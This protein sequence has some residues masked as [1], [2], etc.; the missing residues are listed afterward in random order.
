MPSLFPAC[1]R[2]FLPVFRAPVGVLLALL[3]GCT[4]QVA[5]AQSAERFRAALTQFTIAL[6]GA[7]GDEG[8][9]GT[10]ALDAMTR[11]LPEWD[12]EI[13]TLETRAKAPNAD[14][15]AHAD[16]ARAYL[17]RGRTK[18]AGRE[19]DTARVDPTRVDLATLLGL[20][21]WTQQQPRDATSTFRAAWQHDRSDPVAAYWLLQ[22]EPNLAA[23][24]EG[25][26]LIETLTAAY[27][28]ALTLKT[29][30]SSAP[31][32]AAVPPPPDIGDAPLLLPA[33]YAPGYA[34]LRSGNASGAIAQFRAA[35]QSDPLVSDPAL[36]SAAMTAGSAALRQGRVSAARDQFRTAVQQ[37]PASSEAHRLL[38]LACLFDF[39]P[40]TSIS[41]LKAAVRL[42]PN[43]ERSRILLARLLTQQGD[44]S[45]SE[46]LLRATI[47]ALPDSSLAR[48]WLG[49]TLVALNRGDEAAA[50][51]TTV[52]SGQPISGEARLWST[53]GTLRQN[54]GDAEGAANAYMRSIILSPNETEAHLQRARALLDQD[55]REPAFAEYVATLLL[56]PTDPNAYMGIGQLHLNAGRY[57]EAV[58][59]LQRLVTLQPA[60]A[61]AHYA[62]GTALLQAGRTA[63][64]NRELA[65]FARA[66]SQIAE[67]RRRT[68]TVDVLKQEAAVRVSEG[69]L[70]RAEALWKQIIELE[71]SVAADHMALGAVLVRAN[72]LEMAAASYERAATLGG[73][74]DVYRQLAS[75]YARLGRQADSAAARDKFERSLLV[76]AA[77]GV[78]R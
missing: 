27:R 9:Q 2:R 14:A 18:D 44:P 38:A 62:L 77:P 68:L 40:E 30:P 12:R 52:A 39:D 34:Q 58:T 3:L 71:P 36:G 16:L 67:Q 75:I 19:M 43:D 35:I 74:P 13:A 22:S 66:Q 78:N 56:D 24:S 33:A 61:E 54:A 70:D 10:A 21:Q 59:A 51:L 7:Y 1:P 48:L 72:R 25:A 57:A 50:A 28:R 5:S 41:E 42:R 53:I 26:A 15:Q 23:T 63:E 17:L 8:A 64:G 47:T 45:Q 46:G 6:G 4:P 69:A 32:T 29:R 65:E 55:A 11:I 37:V 76:P 73:G 31:F 49:S 20:N 60:F